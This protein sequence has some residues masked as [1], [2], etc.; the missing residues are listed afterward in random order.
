MDNGT[1]GEHGGKFVLVKSVDRGKGLS[2]EHG[3]RPTKEG[4]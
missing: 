1:G 3:E 2:V 4:G